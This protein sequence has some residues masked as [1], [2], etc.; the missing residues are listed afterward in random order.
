[1]E[2]VNKVHKVR[3][4]DWNVCRTETGPQNQEKQQESKGECHKCLTNS[5]CDASL[6]YKKYIK[7]SG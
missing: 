4:Y 5:P 7:T 6:I 1:M 3:D 2:G